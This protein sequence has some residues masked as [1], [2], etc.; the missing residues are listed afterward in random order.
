MPELAEDI[1]TVILTAR[2]L[3]EAQKTAM[4]D[5]FSDQSVSDDEIKKMLD[6]L[7]DAE[8]S[9]RER[10]NIELQKARAEN[11]ARLAAEEA[12]IAPEKAKIEA[13]SRAEKQAVMSE[14]VQEVHK[15]EGD[16]DKVEEQIV[17]NSKEA[18][19]MGKIRKSLGI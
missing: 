7:C 16:L 6:G 12:R 8:I 14:Y 10:E 1:L 9:L 3:T 17:K 19:E 2:T 11:N 15:L 4:L 13:E 18:D 5:K